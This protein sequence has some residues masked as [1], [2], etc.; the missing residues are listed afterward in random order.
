MFP[1][2]YLICMQTID[3]NCINKHVI[4]PNIPISTKCC[5]RNSRCKNQNW[6]PKDDDKEIL[7][8]TVDVN[9][10]AKEF[11]K[12]EYFHKNHTMVPNKSDYSRKIYQWK[13]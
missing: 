3:L 4:Y 12:H 8:V 11:Q 9:W 6:R 2:F 10:V 7:L 13:I 5:Y 1:N